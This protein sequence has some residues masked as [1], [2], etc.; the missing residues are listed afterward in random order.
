MVSE[1]HNLYFN[2]FKMEINIPFYGLFLI[3]LMRH[4]QCAKINVTWV[5]LD[6]VYP[7]MSPI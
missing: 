2:T 5:N 6:D 7:P 3:L 1:G 4:S